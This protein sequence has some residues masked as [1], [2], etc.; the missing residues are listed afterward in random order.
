[1]LTRK[2]HF[3]VRKHTGPQVI[4]KVCMEYFDVVGYVWTR[5]LPRDYQQMVVERLIDKMGF[6]RLGMCSCI[7]Y[8]EK[9]LLPTCCVCF[10]FVDDFIYGLAESLD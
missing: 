3:S 6:Q 2:E 9:T 4:A 1:M 5:M 10:Q 8:E 7:L